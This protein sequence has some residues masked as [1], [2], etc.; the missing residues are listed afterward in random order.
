MHCALLCLKLGLVVILEALKM[1][2]FRDVSTG[3]FPRQENEAKN[4]LTK[5]SLR[6]IIY[7]FE[8][9]PCLAFLSPLTNLFYLT[10]IIFEVHMLRKITV[11][12]PCKI[13][14]P[15]CRPEPSQSFP[16]PRHGPASGG[17]PEYSNVKIYGSGSRTHGTV[18]IISSHRFP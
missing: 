8:F 2:V 9:G 7:Y 3:C 1:S 5:F 14:F 4:C 13:L 18:I 12:Y 6:T 11:N 15:V 17:Y 16:V 10:F